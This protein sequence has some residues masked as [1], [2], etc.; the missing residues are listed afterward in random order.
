MS[1]DRDNY[2]PPTFD[3]IATMRANAFAEGRKQGVAEERARVVADGRSMA[4]TR[5]GFRQFIDR[6][7]HGEHVPEAGE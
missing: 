7:E 5:I 4:V 6:I 3:E 1:D 2:A